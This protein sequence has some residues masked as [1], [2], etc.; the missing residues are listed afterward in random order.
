MWQ[1]Q[2][3][4]LNIL[5]V[6]DSFKELFPLRQKKET[7]MVVHAL[8]FFRWDLLLEEKMWVLEP[9]KTDFRLLNLT[10]ATF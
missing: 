5:L 9:N 8:V 3:E 1:S 7:M 2:N 6:M 4:N 10:S